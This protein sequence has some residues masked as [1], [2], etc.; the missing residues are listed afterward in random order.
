MYLNASLC[1]KIVSSD[2]QYGE[3]SSHVM[4][5]NSAG[6]LRGSLRNS[7]CSFHVWWKLKY[8]FITTILRG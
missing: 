5:Q 1:G 8:A 2:K 4:H 6:S 7:V 3:Y